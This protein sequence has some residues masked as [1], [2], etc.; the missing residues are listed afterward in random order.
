MRVPGPQDGQP[1]VVGPG[2]GPAQPVDD[3]HAGQLVEA[4]AAARRRPVQESTQA[5]GSNSRGS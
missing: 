5:T 4:D 3:V 1:G 2:A